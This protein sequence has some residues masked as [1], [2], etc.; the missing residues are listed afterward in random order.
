MT[1]TSSQFVTV[2]STVHTLLYVAERRELKLNYKIELSP[3]RYINEGVE[4][5]NYNKNLA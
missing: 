2:L 4:T 5:G 1:I 3:S